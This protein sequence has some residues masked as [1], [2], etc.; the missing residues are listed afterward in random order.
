LIRVIIADDHSIVREG[1][2]QLLQDVHDM[3]VIDTGNYI[4]Y[5]YAEWRW[6]GNSGTVEKKKAG[7]TGSHIE[8]ASGREICNAVN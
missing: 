8:Y 5:L 1:L 3:E 7:N 2:K 6:F 4:G